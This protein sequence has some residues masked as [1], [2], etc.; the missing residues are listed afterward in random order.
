M[1]RSLVLLALLAATCAKA[2]DLDG[3]A[4][5]KDFVAQ[6][7]DTVK[8]TDRDRLG[9]SSDLLS[10]RMSAAMS[11]SAILCEPRDI[12]A[13]RADLIQWLAGRSDLQDKSAVTGLRMAMVE[14]YTC[15]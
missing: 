5:V 9:C 14:L 10:A 8:E 13:E 6:C 4:K 15:H 7:A 11:G 12:E 2:G 3:P 1:T